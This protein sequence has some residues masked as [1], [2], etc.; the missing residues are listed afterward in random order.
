MVDPNTHS[1]IRLRDSPLNRAAV[2]RARRLAPMTAR[3]QPIGDGISKKVE[4]V[5]FERLRTSELTS[6]HFGQKH[7]AV[8]GDDC[9]ENALVARVNPVKN[10]DAFRAA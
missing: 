9:P 6:N 7:R 5:G 3:L 8:D 1:A 2:A 10:G 4:R